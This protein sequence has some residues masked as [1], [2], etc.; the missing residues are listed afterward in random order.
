MPEDLPRNRL[1]LAKWI[2]DASNPLT[3]RVVVNQYWQQHFGTGIVKTAEDFGSQGEQPSHPQ[4]LDWLAT[5][6]VRTG[7]DIKAMQR[8]IVTSA[9]Y[10]QSSRASHELIERDPENRLLA[11][12]P[13]FRLPAEIVRDNA[14]AISGLLVEKLG[15]PPVKPYQPARPWEG[16]A[17]GAGRGADGPGQGAE[18]YRPRPHRSPQRAR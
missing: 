18:P 12:G 6:F 15:G 11:R 5:E 10:R 2:V 1:G 14:L 7:W 16:L 3:A 9:T 4:L 13:R 17:R 8:L